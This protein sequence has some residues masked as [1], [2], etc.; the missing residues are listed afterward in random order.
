M[1]TV[2]VKLKNQLL[3]LADKYETKQFLANDPSQFMHRYSTKRDQEVIAFIAANLAFGRRDQILS[4]VEAIC[5]SI[6]QNAEN[7]PAGWIEN[8]AYKK[9]FTLGGSS[10]YRMMSHNTM[11]LLCDRLREL[12]REHNSF[13]SAVKFAWLQREEGVLFLHETIAS[14]FPKE[15]SIISHG[16]NS[17]SKRLQMFLR[18]M[19]RNSSP[20]DLGLWS[21]WYDKKN[22]LMPLDTH[23]MQEAV[24]FGLLEKTSSGKIPSPSLKVAVSLTQTLAQVFPDD[25]VRADYALFG[26]GVD[27]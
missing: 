16:R 22:L 11:L 23:V 3:L 19:V 5:S 9:L 21:S 26:L 14:L 18:W 27:A 25:P 4:H 1:K 8:S 13:G 20:V 17:S 2:P 12:L 10:F 7:S 24:R 6:R 15:C